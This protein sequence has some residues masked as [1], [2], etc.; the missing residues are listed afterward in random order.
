MQLLRYLKV[1]NWRGNLI[2]RCVPKKSL[3][4][5]EASLRAFLTLCNQP[6]LFNTQ[7]QFSSS[8]VGSLTYSEFSS[9]V[10]CNKSLQLRLLCNYMEG[11]FFHSSV[12]GRSFPLNVCISPSLFFFLWMSLASPA[13]RSTVQRWNTL[14]WLR[15]YVF[16]SAGLLLQTLTFRSH[17]FLIQHAFHFSWIPF[18]F[19][20]S[21]VALTVSM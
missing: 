5:F 19:F 12:H 2:R 15:V 11:C 14:S 13:G 20:F 4:S 6:S 10:C 7:M 9:P 17:C 8:S 16:G 1:N 18:F 3:W 21:K